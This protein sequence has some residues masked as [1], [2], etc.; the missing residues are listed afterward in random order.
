MVYIPNGTF[1]IGSPPDEPN[2]QS[3]ET[4][5]SVTLTKD[6]LMGKYEVTQELYQAVMGSNPSSFLSNPAEGEVQ[7]RRPV[8]MVS[9]GEMLVFCNKLSM[10]EGLT[11]VYS[12]EGETDPAE[13]GSGDFDV[14]WNANGYRLPT[15][16]EWE[17]ACRAGTTTAYNTGASI[18]DDTGW[19][20]VNSGSKTHEV[21]KKPANA[22]GLYDMHGNVCER[23]W[24]R[25]EG[26]TAEASTDPKGPDYA[27]GD[28]R[29]VRGGSW[30]LVAQYVRS[31]GR[32]VDYKYGRNYYGFRVVRNN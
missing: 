25:Y 9:W 23:C 19:Y 18:S 20:S 11:P 16:A 31:A 26:Y 14:N 3:N 21:G 22:W 10:L 27:Y 32:D 24:D 15:E 29:M 12:I 4:Q 13:W 1:T 30:Y 28:Y 7:E 2:R 17:Y 5:H 6:F 8:E